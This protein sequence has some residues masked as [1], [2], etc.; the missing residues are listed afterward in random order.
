MAVAVYAV[1]DVAV[2][3][4]VALLQV[5]AV[6]EAEAALTVK[7]NVQDWPPN[8]IAKEAVPEEPGVP[9]ILKVRLPEPLANV[10]AAKVAVSPV[11]PVDEIAVPAA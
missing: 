10:P 9:V 11:T 7:V 8:V 4:K 2:A 6:T 5:S 1:P 3:E